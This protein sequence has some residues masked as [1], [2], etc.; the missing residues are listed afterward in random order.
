MYETTPPQFTANDKKKL[1]APLLRIAFN[2]I[3]SN[4]LA[5]FKHDSGEINILDMRS[6]GAPVTNIRAHDASVSS[7]GWKP[8]G[9]LLASGSE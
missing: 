4:Y 6:P 7:I 2:P 3:D 9:T 1:N 8:D 5:T